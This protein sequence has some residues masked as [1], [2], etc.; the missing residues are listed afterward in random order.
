MTHAEAFRLHENVL[1]I[2]NVEEKLNM[3]NSAS[4]AN[5]SI[6]KIKCHD[7]NGNEVRP[8]FLDI[9]IH[10]LMVD[11]FFHEYFALYAR[12][13]KLKCKPLNKRSKCSFM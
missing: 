9:I 5:K 12:I 13:W 6:P 8:E 2:I 11:C 7:E 1:D 4:P 10:N 3:V